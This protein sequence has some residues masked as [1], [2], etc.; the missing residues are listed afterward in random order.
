[1]LALLTLSAC[2]IGTV[3]GLLVYVFV[4]MHVAAT[5]LCFGIISDHCC[6]PHL[7]TST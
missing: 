1:M 2:M 7:L 5:S 3:V 4:I 6:L